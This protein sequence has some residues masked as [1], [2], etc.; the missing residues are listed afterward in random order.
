V[1]HNI[2]RESG[3]NYE[4]VPQLDGDNWDRFE[5]AQAI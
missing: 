2:I 5:K 3:S 4:I 1:V